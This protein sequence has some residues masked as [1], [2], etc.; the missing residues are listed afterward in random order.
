MW[1]AKQYTDHAL[2]PLTEEG[3]ELNIWNCEFFLSSSDTVIPSKTVPLC[4]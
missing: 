3:K 1:Y 4:Q 2:I